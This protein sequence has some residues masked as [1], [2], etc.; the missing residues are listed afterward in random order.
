VGNFAY[1]LFKN[2]YALAVG[3]TD[4]SDEIAKCNSDVGYYIFSHIKMAKYD[5][6][7]TKILISRTLKDRF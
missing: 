4:G 6:I 5:V 1:C 2:F 3:K 7:M